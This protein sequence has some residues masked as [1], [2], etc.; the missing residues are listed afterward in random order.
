MNGKPWDAYLRLSDGRIEEA[1]EGREDR[2]RAEAARRGITLRRVVRENDLNPD[3]TIKPASAFKRKKITLPSGA[4]EYRTVRPVFRDEITDLSLGVIGGLLFED[5]DRAC[6][7][8]RDLEDLLDACWNSKGSAGSLTGSLTLTRGGTDTE[9]AMARNMVN[10][11]NM[12]SRDKRRRAAEGR[13]RWAGKSYQGGRRPFGYRVAEDTEQYR[14]NLIIDK[15]EAEAIRAAIGDILNHDVSLK[16]IARQWRA[17]GISTVCGNPWSAETVKDTLCKPAIAGLASYKWKPGTNGQPDTGELRDAP[18][19]EIIDRATWEKLIAKLNDPARTFTT[20]NEPRWL[21][22]KWAI[23]GIDG[24]GAVV[25]C[26]GGGTDHRTGKLRPR[27]YSCSAGF[28]LRRHAETCDEY[29]AS[30]IV[31]ILDN[32]DN[33]DLLRPPARAGVDVEALKSESARLTKKKAQLARMLTDDEIEEADCKRETR[34]IRARLAEIAG[35]LAAT[36]APDPLAEFRGRPA[37]AVWD[38]LPI[39]RRREVAK[40]LVEVKFMPA[41]P[42]GPKFDDR[43]LKVWPRGLPEP[44]D[45]HNATS[46]I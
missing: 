14:R 3:G 2:L 26:T 46:V 32:P 27:A 33:A 43:A 4:V 12:E 37:Q 38:S 13:E 11:K 7:D 1:F 20:S 25:T 8:P 9:I 16:A 31:R 40:L 15:A 17:E 36:G 29:V 35:Q 19:D 6:R 23:C 39:A 10:Y 28:H 5:L 42:R 34:R 24:C 30:A 18:W 45:G 22:S 41:R 21:L 44:V